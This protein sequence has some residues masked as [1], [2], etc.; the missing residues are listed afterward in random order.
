[1]YTI[2]YSPNGRQVASTAKN[3]AVQIWDTTTGSCLWTLE[4]HTEEVNRILYSPQGDVVVSAGDDKTVRL[5]DAES[6]QCRGVIQD[7]QDDVKDIDWVQVS[8]VDHLVTGCQDGA[9]RMWKLI[10]DGDQYRVRLRWSSMNNG[11]AVSDAIIQDAQGLSELNRHLLRQRGTVGEP[12]N[13]FRNA[14]RRLTSLAATLNK[15]RMAARTAA[16]SGAPIVAS[17]IVEEPV[18]ELEKGPVQETEKDPVQELEKNPVQEPEKYPVQ[19]EAKEPV[20]A[21]TGAIE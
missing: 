5:W 11:L 1:V 10:N 18:Q 19:I 3:G 7:L 9:V 21:S 20:Q 8:G 14:G 13:Q 2:S 4:G 15:F 16:A 12:F 6:G 17:S